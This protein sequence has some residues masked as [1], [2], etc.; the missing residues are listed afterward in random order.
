MTYGLWNKI[1]T[2]GLFTMILATGMICGT[3]SARYADAR[4]VY[5][6]AKSG[7]YTA[8]K[9]LGSAIDAE[10]SSGNTA[11][12]MALADG[13][14]RAYHT[15]LQYGA[16]PNP[17]CSY[18]ASYGRS[19]ASTG[20][21]S[22][23][24]STTGWLVAGA[25]VAGG[26]GIAAAAGGGGGGG[27]GGSSSSGECDENYAVSC[28]LGYV[29]TG[30]TC[31]KDGQMLYECKI[32]DCMAYTLTSVPEHCAIPESCRSG[33]VTT[34]R[35][36]ACEDGWTGN[37]CE[38]EKI[39]AYTNET[40]GEGYEVA[41][42]CKSGDKTYVKCEPKACE[43]FDFPA[44]Y[45]SHCA[46]N[47]SE[48]CRNG[49]NNKYKCNKCAEG[50][51]GEDCNTPVKCAYQTTSCIESEGYVPTGETCKSGD[52]LYVECEIKDC[53]EYTLSGVPEKCLLYDICITR[54]AQQPVQKVKC[55]QCAEGWVGDD[56]ETED[57]CEG[58]SESCGKGYVPAE[59]DYCMSGNKKL[60]MCVE[61]DCSEYPLQ[62]LPDG[63]CDEFVSCQSGDKTTYRCNKCKKGWTGDGCNTEETCPSDYVRADLCING[64]E[65][66]GD[67]CWEGD[68][69]LVK[70][71]EIPC[72]GHDLTACPVNAE[73]CSACKSDS[74]WKYK[75]SVC[76][77][78]W[79]GDTCSTPVTCGY[80]TLEC[81]GGYVETGNYCWSAGIKYTE[82]KPRE[83]S[84]TTTS[85]ETGYEPTGRT[86]QSADT[87]YQECQKVSC[88]YHT[89]TCADGYYETGAACQSGED[90]YKECKP[91]DCS[92]FPLTVCPANAKG[93]CEKCQSGENTVRYKITG[94][95]TGWT[96]QDCSTPDASC[97]FRDTFCD[98]SDGYEETGAYCYYGNQ[99]YVECAVS[100]CN[101]P[102]YPYDKCPTNARSC[103]IC[104]TDGKAKYRTY[105]C[106]DGWEGDDCATEKSCDGFS[107][108][109]CGVGFYETGQTCKS[110]DTTY[111]KC[112]EN[113]CVGY[114]LGQCPEKAESC[115]RCQ[116]G[117]GY[118]YKL[119]S[120]EEGWT[121]DTC[122]TPA[123]CPYDTTSCAGG[124]VETGNKCKSGNEWYVECAAQTCG[125]YYTECGQGYD[126]VEGDTCMSG[127]QEMVRCVEHN[128][129]TEFYTTCPTGYE[130]DS[131]KPQCRS[132]KKIMVQCK[133]ATCSGYPSEGKNIEH[134]KTYATPCQAGDKSMYKC[135]DCDDGYTG[136][137][138]GKCKAAEASVCTSAGFVYT[139]YGE[140]KEC[141]TPGASKKCGETTYYKCSVCKD[142]M[143]T[144]DGKCE[145]KTESD[146]NGAGYWYNDANKTA[147]GCKTTDT[148]SKCLA[149]TTSYYKC[150]N[151]SEGWTGPNGGFCEEVL[152]S[153]CTG[154]KPYLLSAV[155]TEESV[156][157]KASDPDNQYCMSGSNK[158]V[159]CAD[160]K[161]SYKGKAYNKNPA[162]GICVERTAEGCAAEGK[163]IKD[164]EESA[165]N[166]ANLNKSETP[167]ITPDGSSYYACLN[168]VSPGYVKDGKGG[169]MSVGDCTQ[170]NYPLTSSPSNCAAD[171]QCKYGDGDN[172]W[173]YR[174]DSCN[175]GY[176][177]VT[178]ENRSLSN[179]AEIKTCAVNTPAYCT[180]SGNGGLGYTH[181]G[182]AVGCAQSL[183]SCVAGSTTYY[184][185]CDICDNSAGY[186][187][188]GEGW[189]GTCVHGSRNGSECSCTGNWS[190]ALCDKCEGGTIVGNECVKDT[191]QCSEAYSGYT[192]SYSS[193]ITN[194]RETAQCLSCSAVQYVC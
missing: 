156:C 123:A 99:R 91:N 95:K 74:V 67:E 21:S 33:D 53:S 86:C 39:C 69:L 88:P 170:E 63:N 143:K 182:S 29:E 96:G 174:C 194:C 164:G 187:S 106:Q 176:H 15:L 126:K 128:C 27:G 78:G 58:Y 3:A 167:C 137:G 8:L 175:S 68:K 173:Y 62:Q 31:R 4:S 160:C 18:A 36:D 1:K 189:C 172:D 138:A 89:V 79:E 191:P 124:Y 159:L 52:T 108:T 157:N 136:D 103:G 6:Y 84:F 54:E 98:R 177:M 11:V 129:G 94:C 101:N 145:N 12:C 179:N 45:I 66:A 130:T 80:N 181:S 114:N 34:Y 147:K 47:E 165:A 186:V 190:G 26:V 122:S 139:E 59:N 55:T 32:K 155:G 144:V 75:V 24:M 171:S 9:Y 83:C 146:C 115:D 148:S 56:C 37:L 178:S 184:S 169:C 14:S 188:D 131:S 185:D 153:Q 65:S 162:N 7:N 48:I 109:Y 57:P 105:G 135:Q 113:P 70:C 87:L 152:E 192:Y 140:G 81:T 82:C 183:D 132:G 111:V 92:D 161:V 23:G 149:G 166:C 20:I 102:P 49:D 5:G 25:I 118:K 40:C 73:R 112:A 64:Y 85:C 168:C 90:I 22:G 119:N 110:G 41:D 76:K 77:D 10:D 17:R 97:T 117:E 2:V 193:S 13:N 100:D 134:C 142:G 150:S 120:C 30:K 104:M 60:L 141:V 46:E 93:E 72:E 38:R 35:C 19:G 28:P 43:G 158:Y 180:S 107:E 51:K 44:E 151:C 154:E 133:V 127:E 16:N 50:W 163:P 42:T 116:S 71:Q 121:G 61:R 125:G